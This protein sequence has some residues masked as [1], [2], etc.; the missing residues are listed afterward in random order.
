[1]SSLEIL[2]FFDLHVQYNWM[3]NLVNIHVQT[4]YNEGDKPYLN[5]KS[6]YQITVHVSVLHLANVNNL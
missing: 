2:I 5:K 6:F 4:Y 1:M 3:Y